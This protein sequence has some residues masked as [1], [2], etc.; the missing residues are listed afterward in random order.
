[1]CHSFPRHLWGAGGAPG[2]AKF[3]KTISFSLENK[4]VTSSIQK[5]WPIKTYFKF[6]TRQTC[7]PTYKRSHEAQSSKNL[8]NKNIVGALDT[9]SNPK[10]GAW[11]GGSIKLRM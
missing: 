3:F 1:M 8:V 7:L 6:L 10:S 5:E 4:T 9:K 11:G 2:V